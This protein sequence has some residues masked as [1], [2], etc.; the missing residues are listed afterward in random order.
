[1]GNDCAKIRYGTVHL[2]YFECRLL[3]SFI[4]SGLEHK[5]TT[6]T[7]VPKVP[8]FWRKRTTGVGISLGDVSHHLVYR[9]VEPH[10]GSS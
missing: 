9:W 8:S 1:M 7:P 5:P 4:D 2:Y 10:R 6:P 3:E